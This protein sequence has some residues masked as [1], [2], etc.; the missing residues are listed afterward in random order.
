MGLTKKETW[1]SNRTAM[2]ERFRLVSLERDLKRLK[3][4]NEALKRGLRE[5]VYPEL[6][7]PVAGKIYELKPTGKLNRLQRI[8]LKLKELLDSV[9]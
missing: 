9:S 8:L 2:A 3:R 6:T 5:I 4:E 1:M 7:K